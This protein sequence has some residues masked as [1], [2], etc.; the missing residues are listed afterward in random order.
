ML[1]AVTVNKGH[2]C[3]GETCL[4]TITKIALD[5]RPSYLEIVNHANDHYHAL[6]QVDDDLSTMEKSKSFLHYETVRNVP[7][8]MKYMYSH[9]VT[10]SEKIGELPYFENDSIVDYVLAFGAVKA[11]QRFGWVALRQYRNIKEFYLDSRRENNEKQ[12]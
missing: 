12:K 9:D 7:A 2:I 11:V 3:Y 1:Y 5:F 4:D 6:M 10:D 8:Y